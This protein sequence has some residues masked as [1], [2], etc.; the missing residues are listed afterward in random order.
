M[1]DAFNSVST[2]KILSCNEFGIKAHKL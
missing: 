1:L 2:H